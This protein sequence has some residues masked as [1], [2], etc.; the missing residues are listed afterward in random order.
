MDMNPNMPAHTVLSHSHIMIKHLNLAQAF[1][2][3]VTSDGIYL[4]LT[5]FPGTFHKSSPQPN[6]YKILYRVDLSWFTK[7]FY[8]A[9][10]VDECMI[11]C[12]VGNLYFCTWIDKTD[13]VLKLAT[14][15]LTEHELQVLRSDGFYMSFAA[16]VALPA[17]TILAV[18]K[19][20]PELK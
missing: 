12:K 3:E 8:N 2:I 5:S 10:D 1:T 11:T 13:A 6:G 19:R 4:H 9:L 18:F 17:G 7:I 15:E 20:I 16:D 14:N